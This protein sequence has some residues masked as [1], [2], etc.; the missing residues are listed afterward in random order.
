MSESAYTV[1]LADDMVPYRRLVRTVLEKSGSFRV[2]GEV[3]DGAEVIELTKAVKPDLVLLDLGM[4]E[5]DGLEVLS[6]ISAASPATKVVILSGFS[7]ECMAAR[8]LSL[9]A[10]RYLEKGIHPKA[11]VQELLAAMR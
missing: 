10:V 8:G 5:M 6:Q 11:L 9:G 4:P 7:E 2:V 3:G 1:I